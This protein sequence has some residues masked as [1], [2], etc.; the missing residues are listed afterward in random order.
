MAE[1]NKLPVITISREYGAGGRT[2]AKALAEHLG[3]EYYDVD[4]VRLT[5]KA[6]GFSEEDIRREGEDMSQGAKLINDFLSFTATTTSSYDSIYQAQREVVLKL[7]KSPCII[8]GRCSNII[9]REEGIPSFDVFLYAD[10]AHRIKRALELAENGKEDIEK[11]LEK[12]DQWRQNYYKEY[13]KH[14]MGEC[15]DYTICLD[16]GSIG[17]Q[18]CVGILKQL[19]DELY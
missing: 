3:I 12:R 1:K 5:A 19:L 9:L 11:Y 15:R 13:T 10:K 14:Q 16:T 17:T 8:V 18:R 4:F 2:V 6:S 7:A